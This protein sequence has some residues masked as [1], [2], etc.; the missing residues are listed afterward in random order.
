MVLA[1]IE[2]VCRFREFAGIPIGRNEAM[3]L[4]KVEAGQTM[5]HIAV[6]FVHE[7]G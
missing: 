2:D 1:R 6:Y 3:L 5:R 4:W 7:F